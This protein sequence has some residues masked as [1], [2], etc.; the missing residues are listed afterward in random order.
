M[1]EC[2]IQVLLLSVPGCIFLRILQRGFADVDLKHLLTGWF[3][4]L[5]G[6]SEFKSNC[7]GIP[8]DLF[9]LVDGAGAVP[10][11]G[12]GLAYAVV[13]MGSIA[14][15]DGFWVGLDGPLSAEVHLYAVWLDTGQVLYD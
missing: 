13:V 1:L 4:S 11:G 5:R 15:M 10:V 12:S 3:R 6:C 7:C 9:W 8:A 14:E 2:V